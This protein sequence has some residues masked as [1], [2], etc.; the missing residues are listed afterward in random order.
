MS[1]TARTLAAA[2]FI[3]I[4]ALPA[5][6]QQKPQEPSTEHVR[7]LIAQAMQQTGQQPPVAAPVAPPVLQA[8][9][10]VN[11]T[12]QE[13]VA[14]ATER[15][16]TLISERITPQTWDFTMAATRANYQMNLTSTVSNNSQVRLTTDIFSGGNRITTD[17]QSWS[18]GLAQ[19]V[20]WG[21]GNYTVNW[22]N[23]RSSTDS[24]STTFNPSFNSGLQAR[25]T[26][27]LLRNFK[28]D[29]T[30]ATI[31][32][33]EISQNIAELNLSASEVSVLAQTRNAYWELVYARQAV[34][35]AEQSLELATKL[36]GDNRMR[37]EI[38]TMAPIDV[39]QAQAEE[40]NRRQQLVT[41]Q[42]TLRNNELA[43]K[44]LIVSGTDDELWR[45]TIVPVD[46]PTVTAQPLDLESAVR[47]ALSQRT[48]LAITKMNLEAADITL[49]SLHNQTLPNLDLIGQYNLTGQG[50]TFIDRDRLTGEINQTFPG[51]Y[52]DALRAITG[53]DAPQ[54]NI[55]VQFAYPIGTSAQEAN[56]ARQRL[57]R[58]Q[59]ESSL[60]TT[61]LQIATEVTAAALAVRNSLEAMQ[62]A[63]VSR[64]LSEQ[65]LQAVQSKFDVGMSTNFEVVQAQ[66]DLNDA[67]NSELRQQLNYQRALVD[68]Q[69]VQISP[70]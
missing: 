67:R 21:G 47:N 35:A 46:R 27:P 9:P 22:T 4:S 44:R 42:A 45:A 61:E 31:L 70:R 7:S 50:G 14:R 13:A 58:R 40:A 68:F 57:L 12:E 52:A 32:T 63:T 59:T 23:S 19:N 55:Q 36:V 6:A 16:L 10:A 49:R 29:N 24:E 48:D 25:F 33:N 20:W 11:L 26:Q 39:V 53:F 2:G 38:G 17:S 5:L 15:N 28:I 62:A 64:A 18:A 66:R 8:G 51:G 3:V 54:W 65:R 1:K 37:V 34:E 56:V 60:K 69:R 41:A 30:R 43:L